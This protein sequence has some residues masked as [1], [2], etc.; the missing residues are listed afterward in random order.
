MGC[1]LIRLRTHLRHLSVAGAISNEP[2]YLAWA[3]RNLLELAVWAKY[4]AASAEN[5]KRV[6]NDS[7]IDLAEFQGA[8]LRLARK[9]EPTHS[10]IAALEQ[11]GQELTHSQAAAGLANDAKHLNIGALAREVGMAAEFYGFNAILSKLVHPTSFS[12]LLP[13]PLDRGPME[14]LRLAFLG[15]GLG[16]TDDALGYAVRCFEGQGLDCTMLRAGIG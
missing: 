9:F 6:S 12:I 2:E 8:A 14:Q 4:V 16:A 7:L 3:V 5:A 1:I 10:E 13:L 11:Q 15:L